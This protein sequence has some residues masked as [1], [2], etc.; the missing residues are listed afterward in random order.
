MA[1]KVTDN[2][3]S[4]LNNVTGEVTPITTFYSGKKDMWEKVYA[5]SLADML[6]ISGDEKTRVIA[7]LI[8][9]KDSMNRVNETTASLAEKSGVSTKTVKR[10]LKILQDNNFIH[11][12][13]NGLWLF[14]PNIMVNGK[15]GYGAA[16]F[17]KWD[18]EKEING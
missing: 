6:E 16:V 3:F 12:V 13:R 11:R 17:R 4:L 7:C 14:S 10:T 18:M 2:E 8:K 5:K 15:S 1:V 9:H